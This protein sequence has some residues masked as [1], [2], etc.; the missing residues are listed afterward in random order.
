MTVLAIDT[1]G[2]TL[3]VGLYC[4]MSPRASGQTYKHVRRA[5]LT[6]SS[7]LAPAIECLY[8]TADASVQ[9]TDLIAVSAGPGSFTGLRIGMASAKGIAAASGADIVSVPTLAAICRSYRYWDGVVLAAIDARKSRF[10]VRAEHS[11]EVLVQDADMT[12]SDALATI[13]SGRS[14]VEPARLLVVGPGA[15]QLSEASKPQSDTWVIDADPDREYLTSLT[16]MGFELW[17]DQGPDDAA[18]G[19]H[20]LRRGDVG[21]PAKQ[22]HPHASL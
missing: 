4:H 3:A 16:E 2:P 10:Y 1:H 9:D 18:A 20:Y 12:P 14:K 11:A 13:R 6:H 22:R 21:T 17:K 5:G 7:T 15:L 19:P 8:S